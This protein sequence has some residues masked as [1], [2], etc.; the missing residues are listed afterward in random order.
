MSQR[1]C[2]GRHGPW[3][4]QGAG[5]QAV[6]FPGVPEEANATGQL[7]LAAVFSADKFSGCLQC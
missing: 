5:P 1:A 7:L 4:R 6:V 3:H 2:K